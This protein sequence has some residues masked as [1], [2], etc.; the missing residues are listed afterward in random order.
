MSAREWS[1]RDLYLLG[2]VL[3]AAAL[4]L[5]PWLPFVNGPHLWFGLPSMVVW[6]MIWLLLLVPALAGIEWGRT[7]YLED[8]EALAN[9]AAGS[10]EGG[11][12]Q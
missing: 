11:E 3:P 7:R 9:S 8:A 6:P 5:T 10:V 2:P 12:P 1:T 4:V